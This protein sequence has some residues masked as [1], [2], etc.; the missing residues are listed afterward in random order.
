[1]ECEQHIKMHWHHK[2][3]NLL[4]THIGVLAAGKGSKGPNLSLLLSHA[5]A[6]GQ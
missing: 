2:A 4:L 3:A 6:A 5:F 1:M